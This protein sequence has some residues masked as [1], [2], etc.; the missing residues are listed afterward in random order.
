MRRRGASLRRCLCEAVAACS[1][2]D[3]AKSDNN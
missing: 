3:D 1:V 2:K